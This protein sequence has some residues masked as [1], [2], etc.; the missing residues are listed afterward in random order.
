MCVCVI[1]GRPTL[2]EH[3]RSATRDWRF[4]AS[5]PHVQSR[6]HG[7]RLWRKWQFTITICT[8][9]YRPWAAWRLQ[10]S[11]YVGSRPDPGRHN[12][13][14]CWIT[15]PPPM[16]SPEPPPGQDTM[17]TKSLYRVTS[18]SWL[19][20]PPPPQ[21]LRRSRC[22]DDG[23]TVSK[24]IMMNVLSMESRLNDFVLFMGR[25]IKV[26]TDSTNKA[27]LDEHARHVWILQEVVS[28]AASVVSG[29][30][31]DLGMLRLT[32][33][34]A[35]VLQWFGN[36]RVLSVSLQSFVLREC[37][38]QVL[39]QASALDSACPRW[40]AHGDKHHGRLSAAPACGQP[41]HRRPANQD[42]RVGRPPRVL[43]QSRRALEGLPPG[44]PRH[45]GPIQDGNELVSSWEGHCQCGGS[46]ASALRAADP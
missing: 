37:S 6:M 25:A 28:S 16:P 32:R 3:P 38:K 23:Q 9:V 15:P 42:P 19:G 41:Q 26:C 39:D 35:T 8:W 2:E 13:L 46:D 11:Q 7:G 29:M 4:G 43:A 31:V 34:A 17:L 30:K 40:G 12:R 36:V 18:Q 33:S 27:A 14:R 1:R 45:Q 20:S 24:D 22:D 10:C 44:P 21:T 5:D